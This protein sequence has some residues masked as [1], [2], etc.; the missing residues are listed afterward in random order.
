V[1]DSAHGQGTELQA[2]LRVRYDPTLE[3]KI[4]EALT[5]Q[6]DPQGW[7]TDFAIDGYDSQTVSRH[8][9]LAFE[10]G[11]ID[12]ID[13]SSN[14]GFEWAPKRLMPSG[15]RLLHEKSPLVETKAAIAAGSRV[16]W[17]IVSAVAASVATAL[18]VSWM[19]NQ[20]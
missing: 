19:N 5:V 13:L 16:I 1:V 11:L 2:N 14:D 3:L 18:I 20:P 9:Q 6:S 12:A 17:P 15:Y 8:I 10:K 4:L 7:V